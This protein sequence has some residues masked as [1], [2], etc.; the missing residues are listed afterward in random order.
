MQKGQH[1]A[2]VILIRICVKCQ[3]PQPK[4]FLFTGIPIYGIDLAS[5]CR[6]EGRFAVVTKRG[7]GCDGPL[8][9]V[10]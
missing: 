8:A 6:H 3:V 9:G 4:I 7:A 1:S 2:R 5:P 10:R